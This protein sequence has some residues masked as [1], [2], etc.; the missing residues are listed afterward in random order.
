MKAGIV[1]LNYKTPSMCIKLVNKIY[2][3]SSIMNIVLV[4]NAS[5]DNSVMLL[6]NFS[7]DKSDKVTFIMSNENGGYARGNNIGLKYLK[8]N[9]DVDIAF[10]CNPDVYFEENVILKILEAF[11]KYPEYVQ[12]S[13]RRLDEDDNN[14]IRQY[15]DFPNYC[16]ELMNCF[17]VTR[18]ILKKRQVY[19]LPMVN[20]PIEVGVVPGAF[21][22]IRLDILDK[23]GFL[24]EGTFLFYEENCLAAKLGK[25]KRAIIPYVHYNTYKQ[26]GSTSGLKR[27]CDATRIT[28]A[29]Q[30]YFVKKYLNI[31]VIKRIVLTICC[32]IR[33]K[34][35]ELQMAMLKFFRNNKR[36]NV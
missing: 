22:A 19:D 14:T 33:L 9:T 24:D 2:Q 15:W 29:S 13:C 6:K 30:K 21:F 20:Y 34:E 11:E 16:T 8:N 32:G 31:C 10:V 25:Y 35:K 28:I 4:D 18:K 5:M 7:K 1:I 3:Y 27:S 12:L 26:S 23:I 36:I 17:V